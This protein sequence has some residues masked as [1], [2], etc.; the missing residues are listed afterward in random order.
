MATIQLTNEGSA[1]LLG[2]PIALYFIEYTAICRELDE[3]NAAMEAADDESDG[4]EAAFRQYLD[5][6]RV[7]DDYC[8]ANGR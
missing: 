1:K 4:Y 5:A 7:W 8:V 6:Y 2:L 3:A